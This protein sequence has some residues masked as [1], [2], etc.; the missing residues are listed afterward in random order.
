MAVSSAIYSPYP[1]DYLPESG[2]QPKD[3]TDDHRQQMISICHALEVYFR[4]TSRVYI[5]GGIPLYYFDRENYLQHISPDIF[6]VRGVERR[7]RRFYDLR[8]ESKAP[9]IVIELTSINTKFE[10][11]YTKRDIYAWLGICEYF[12]FVPAEIVPPI[13]QGFHLEGGDYIPMPGSH[14]Q[15]EVLGL[16]LVVEAGQLRFY[17][18]K[19]GERLLTPEEAEAERRAE[20]AA[21][22]A[23][24]AENARLR[25][26]LAKLQVKKS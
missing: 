16:D 8:E 25:E 2:E 9:D 3:N 11:L 1:N 22:Q 7:N 15:S 4:E 12:I 20:K 5:S 6:V 18:P 26:E 17:D 13:L 19:T 14:F 23:A 24:E 10:D 21:R